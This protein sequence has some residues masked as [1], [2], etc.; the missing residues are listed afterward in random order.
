MRISFFTFFSHGF[1]WFIVSNCRITEVAI[2]LSLKLQPVKQTQQYRFCRCCSFF[3]STFCNWLIVGV[4]TI[5]TTEVVIVVVHRNFLR[6]YLCSSLL[7]WELYPIFY[8]L[9]VF[10]LQELQLCLVLNLFLVALAV[11]VTGFIGVA[12]AL[13]QK[14]QTVHM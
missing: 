10:S 2:A 12:I 3:C 9:Q 8:R 6:I 1:D 11:F 13:L 4:A 14:L 7:L 5:I